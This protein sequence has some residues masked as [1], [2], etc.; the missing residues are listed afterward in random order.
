MKNKRDVLPACLLVSEEEPLVGPD[1]EV[2]SLQS[3]FMLLLITQTIPAL[4]NNL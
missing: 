3:I 4:S 2:P 1:V